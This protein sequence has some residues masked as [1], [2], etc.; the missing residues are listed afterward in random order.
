M[1][2]SGKD[3]RKLFI[4][5]GYEIVPGGGKGSHW[6]LRKQGRPTVIIPNHKELAIG[7]E[8]ALKKML[9][10]VKRK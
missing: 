2:I 5:A 10:S 6:K 7:T 4:E 8:H 1:P 3:M 9:D